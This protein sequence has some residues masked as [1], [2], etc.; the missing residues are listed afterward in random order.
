MLLTNSVCQFSHLQQHTAAR[1]FPG[2][3]QGAMAQFPA[4]RCAQNPNCHF[5]HT[6]QQLGQ[7]QVK[8]EHKHD[9]NLLSYLWSVQVRPEIR[10]KWGEKASA[11]SPFS[12]AAAA[13]N[14]VSAEGPQRLLLNFPQVS[15]WAQWD[16]K[17]CHLSI[18]P[19]AQH[20]SSLRNEA[21]KLSSENNI[22]LTIARDQCII[23]VDGMFLPEK[24]NRTL[25]ILIIFSCLFSF[26]LYCL[27]PN[28]IQRIH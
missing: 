28:H 7:Q 3:L 15:V 10:Q 25:E 21:L 8:P 26:S 12:Q 5:C 22:L 27:H 1:Y 4:Q 6:W 11:A 23:I 17:E 13:T 16:W 9:I 20:S 19:R 18:C 14:A 24:Q 2:V